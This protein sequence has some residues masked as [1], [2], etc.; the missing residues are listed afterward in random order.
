[1]APAAA[2]DGPGYG[3][4]ADEL[5]V[6]WAE[7]DQ[8]LAMGPAGPAIELEQSGLALA[9]NGVGFRGRSEVVVTVGTNE[10]ITARVDPTGT[11]ALSVDLDRAAAGPQPGTS[12]VALGRAPGGTS[13]TLVGAVPPIPAGTGPADLVP[14]IVGLGLAGAGVVA[15]R[16]RRVTA[17]AD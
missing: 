12:V 4:T 1:M 17:S 13:R 8:V 5:A 11:L 14:W 10:P 6:S 7:Q 2:Q 16:R 9:V 3:G 15:A